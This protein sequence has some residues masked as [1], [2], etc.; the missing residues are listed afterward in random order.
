M[1][2][3]ELKVG[4]SIKELEGLVLNFPLVCV[5][6]NIFAESKPKLVVLPINFIGSLNNSE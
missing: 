3:Q 5:V 4:G 6:G 1:A 2:T